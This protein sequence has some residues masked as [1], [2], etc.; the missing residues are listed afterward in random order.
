M[1]KQDALNLLNGIESIDKELTA[2]PNAFRPYNYDNAK[3]AMVDAVKN[4]Y[5]DYNK[6][7][8]VVIKLMEVHAYAIGINFDS[9]SPEL[10]ADKDVVLASVKSNY[11]TL[12]YAADELRDNKEFMIKA[13]NIDGRALAY[14]SDRL[15]DNLDVVMEAVNQN[16][17][18][19]GYASPDLYENETVSLAAVKQN[20]LAL[21]ILS[22]LQRGNDDIVMEAVKQNYLAL[23]WADKSTTNDPEIVMAGIK[24]MKEYHDR[25]NHDDFFKAISR[26]LRN[27]P[28]FIK[29]A[30][31]V[32]PEIYHAAF[33]A[34]KEDKSV[35]LAYCDAFNKQPYRHRFGEIPDSLKFDKDVAI[36][37]VK[38]N[39][40][41]LFN[42]RHFHDDKDVV[43]AAVEHDSYWSSLK[44]A[45]ERL[46]D[47]KEVVMHFIKNSTSENSPLLY[48]SDRLKDDIEVVRAAIAKH[49][50]AIED[51]SKRL[52]DNPKLLEEKK[53]LNSIIGNA[54]S[55]ASKQEI[56]HTSPNKDKNR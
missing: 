3:W 1:L 11:N 28:E 33:N 39:G 13:V 16:G 24:N 55:R 23:K 4:L 18:S 9:L 15:K 27:S 30:M 19:I 40:D 32:C 45:S 17:M 49:P 53:S 6:D 52:R 54:T 8:D 25:E 12:N 46:Q 42:L 14:A 10:K 51:A 22:K 21:Q 5:P 26:K 31:K 2:N 20:G 37:A 47:D 38:I 41:N 48:A 50:D 29:E 34:V 35:F 56:D 44:Y 36:A 7:K 43:M